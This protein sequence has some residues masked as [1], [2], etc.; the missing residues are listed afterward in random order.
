MASKISAAPINFEKIPWRTKE[1]TGEVLSQLNIKV[2]QTVHEPHDLFISGYV[3]IFIKQKHDEKISGFIG[4]MSRNEKQRVFRSQCLTRA[5][6]DVLCIDCV[7][8]DEVPA[9][10]IGKIESI[11]QLNACPAKLL[12]SNQHEDF[13]NF[14]YSLRVWL[15][16]FV[17][18]LSIMVRKRKKGTPEEITDGMYKELFLRFMKIFETQ[19]IENSNMH[20]FIIPVGPNRLPLTPDAVVQ[21][22]SC[23]DLENDNSIAVIKVNKDSGG[24]KVGHEEGEMGSRPK[25]LKTDSVTSRPLCQLIGDMIAV[26]PTSVFGSNGIYGFLVKGTKITVVS[27]EADEGFM[28]NLNQGFVEKGCGVTVKCSKECNILSTEGRL[29]LIQTLLDMTDLIQYLCDS[30]S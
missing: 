26:L 3:K 24:E 18:Q 7:S 2:D 8:I 25:K 19:I 30:R 14:A 27:L 1:W 16:Q 22:S 13:T 17:Q 6:T 28:E 5:L 23:K 11:L 29:A 20:S 21:S 4:Q 10:K 12:G 9:F 15:T